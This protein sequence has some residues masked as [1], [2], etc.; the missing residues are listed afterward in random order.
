MMM[1]IIIIIVVI[2]NNN[3]KKMKE[4]E[5]KIENRTVWTIWQEIRAHYI[6]MSN[7]GKRTLQK[8][9]V[10]VRIYTLI[11]ARKQG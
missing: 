2:D 3:T 10:C 7:T 11:Y 9:T 5:K 1:M 4:T 6:S 8:E